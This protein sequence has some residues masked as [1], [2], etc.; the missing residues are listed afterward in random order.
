[1]FKLNYHIIS[2]I[3]LLL[4]AAIASGD[5]FVVPLSVTGSYNSG[6]SR[7]IEVNLGVPLLQ[8]NSAYFICS[9]NVTAGLNYW[10]QPYGSYFNCY[11]S[12]DNGYMYAKGPTVGAATWPS[13][14]LFSGQYLFQPFWSGETWNFLL[15]GHAT[16]SVGM[17]TWAFIPE[18]PPY[19]LPTGYLSSASII[20]DAIPL[21]FP[22]PGA[23]AS[24]EPAEML[25]FVT[26]DPLNDPTLSATWPV[27][28]GVNDVPLATDGNN[29]LKL[30]WTGETDHNV[31]VKHS[32]S[33]GY[34]FDWSD[35]VLLLVDVF[36]ANPS[37]IP[38]TIGL[39]DEACG[40]L[41]AP[42]V[43]DT[44]GEWHTIQFYVGNVEVNGDNDINVIVFQGLAGEAGTIYID[45]LRFGL[46]E[47]IHPR[48]I[49][50]SGYNWR[51][52]DT[53]CG[54]ANPGSNHYSDSNQNVWLDANEYLH[55]KIAH[56][57]GTWYCS[58]VVSDDSLGYGTHIYTV[59]GRIDLLDPNVVFGLFTWDTNAPQ[60]NYREIDIEFS[61]WRNADDPNNA[62]YVIQPDKTGNKERFHIDCGPNDLITNEI[63]W[64]PDKICFKSYYGEYPL[65]DSNNL[66]KSW[67]Y[68]GP[69]IP[70]A[71]G[72]NDR[73]NLWLLP[74]PDSPDGTP[75]DPPTDGN[76]VEDI[77]KSFKFMP[78]GD[79][80]N[81][82][83]VNI[84][85]LGIFMQAWL[86]S[87]GSPNW[88]PD[89]D[90]AVP[91]NNIID[92]SD[93]T[94]FA[95]NWKKGKGL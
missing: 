58:E 19:S 3:A 46:P 42:C 13:P 16:G 6:Q 75:G 33:N 55:L 87:P 64:M 45:N 52:K 72:E 8:V 47:D 12:A 34:T 93:F 56:R 68:T 67:S 66:I 92:F 11:L 50:F 70:P 61:K 20:I 63:N 41:T 37:S 32:W 94:V 82:G 86:T 15:D 69:D 51:L 26:T 31:G 88:N 27:Y 21:T 85:D 7:A 23:L 59:K 30:S 62:Q 53:N 17:P 95:G 18:F 35:K 57:A 89:C 4:A 90:V 40:W 1:M 10:L 2:V 29:V 65:R 78:F 25:L 79:F 39:W 14:Q 76:E 9:G 28:G 84:I 36:F 48:T 43:P 73:M 83:Y 81:D 60:Y 71:G 49:S 22:P 91:H 77:I 44:A 38:T 74:P 5:T 24:Y 80:N 54:T